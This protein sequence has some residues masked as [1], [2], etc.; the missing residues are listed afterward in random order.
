MQTKV[1]RNHQLVSTTR[2]DTVT[3]K[4]GIDR[5][6]AIAK[7]HVPAKL[8]Q[9]STLFGLLPDLLVGANTDCRSFSAHTK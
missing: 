7:P 5:G 1:Y 6:V 2:G 8:G 9:L 3:D 4:T